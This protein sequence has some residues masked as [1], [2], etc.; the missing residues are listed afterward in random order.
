MSTDWKSIFLKF[1]CLYESDELFDFK[2]FTSKARPSTFLDAPCIWQSVD[3]TE[4]DKNV[5]SIGPFRSLVGSLS[6]N[7]LTKGFGFLFLPHSCPT[8][9]LSLQLTYFVEKKFFSVWGKK[10]VGIVGRVQ[11]DYRW[12]R[13]NRFMGTHQWFCSRCGARTLSSRGSRWPVVGCSLNLFV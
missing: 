5:V 8:Q 7:C 6:S 10:C 3:C 11:M 13:S 1:C 4:L 12:M 9:P 2:N